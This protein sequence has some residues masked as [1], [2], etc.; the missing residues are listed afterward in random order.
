[1]RPGGK[2]KEQKTKKRPGRRPTACAECR[3]LKLRCDRNVPCEKCVSRGCGSICPDGELAPGKNN[4]M[5]LANTEELH[6]QIEQLCSRNRELENALR[7]MQEQVSEQPHPL[8]RTDLLS[9]RT[10]SHPGS[11]S[12]PSTSSSSKSPS[13]S[14]IS[15]TT[16]PPGTVDV[17]FEED[18]NVIDAFGTLT[19][20]QRGESS[21]LGKTARPEYM[22]R[23]ANKAQVHSKRSLPRLST[24]VLDLSLQSQTADDTVIK[25]V[26]N[27]LP[28]FPEALHLCDVYLDHGKFMYSPIP[29]KELID[30][31]L[32]SVYEAKSPKSPGHY[33]PLSLLFIVFAIATLFDTNRKPYSDETQEYYHLSKASLNLSPPIYQPTLEAIQTLIHS[34]QYLDLSG[35]ESQGPD[36]AWTY[37][38]HAVRLGHGIGLHLN[39]ARWKLG[40][41]VSARRTR[42]FWQLYVV[43]SWTSLQTGRPPT[44]FSASIDQPLPKESDEVTTPDGRSESNFH[45]WHI[46]YTILL[47]SVLDVA[48][49]PKQPIYSV[50]L[51]LDRKIR[52]FHVPVSW[53][54]PSENEL[55]RQLPEVYM[56]RWLVLSSKEITLLHLHRA[57]FVQALQESP[58]DLQRHRYLPS[59]VAIYR[60]AW[61]LIRGLAMTWMSAPKVLIR[62]NLAWSHGLSA[63][64]VLCLLVT[65]APTSHLTTP[66]LEEL[67]NLISLFDSA[68]ASCQPASD[69]LVNLH[70]IPPP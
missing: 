67:D 52:D 68:S 41:E 66:A 58:A 63:A 6:N 38:G 1:M 27:L 20:D 21:F 25:E 7:L 14:R 42:M 53:R 16:H 46:L 2:E 5:I 70:S 39:P 24:R 48:L 56:F 4:R 23:A 30:D 62:F 8:L 19:M 45:S 61:R 15:P 18:S 54:M 28:S 29:R 35:S 11:S 26:L 34:A 12:G 3:R 51:D 40:D 49:G 59:V 17:T 47:H 44:I 32:S 37:I 57:H 64:T 69:L 9:L 36:S 65:R 43:D 10:I 13:T 33:H 22:I 55:S 31:I 60:S 50:I